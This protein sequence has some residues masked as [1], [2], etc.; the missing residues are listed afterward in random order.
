MESPSSVVQGPAV[1]PSPAPKNSPFVV[2]SENSVPAPE[3]PS[4]SPVIEKKEN[5]KSIA[6]MENEMRSH[7]LTISE[8]K[9]QHKKLIDTTLNEF[10]KVQAT[11]QMIKV[12]ERDV[13]AEWNGQTIPPPELEPPK[14]VIDE[15]P[16]V[17]DPGNG[18]ADRD[19]ENFEKIKDLLKRSDDLKAKTPAGAV[20]EK[21]KILIV[22]D[23]PTCLKLLGHFLAKEDYAVEKVG[24]AEDGIQSVRRERPDLILLDIMLP[25]AD[26][27]QF[28]A[29]LKEEGTA[30]PP[31]FVISSLTKE[32]NIIKALQGGA[33]DYIF[34]PFSPGIVLAKINQFF[35]TGR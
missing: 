35:R 6:S 32:S 24:N 13:P 30:P 14:K 1:N 16:P 28:L 26:G 23:D 4:I 34:K 3:L 9:L 22:E 29:L 11:Y 7:L 12:L 20:N 2:I 25:G 21:K 5:Q 8:L 27:F 33:T 10:V 19:L 18:Q 15:A 17:V 31:V